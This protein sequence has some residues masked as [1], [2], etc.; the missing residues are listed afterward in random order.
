MR[1]SPWLKHLLKEP[2]GWSGG[3]L[4]AKEGAGENPG[5]R[6]GS[7]A[8]RKQQGCGH[9]RR[10]G[11]HPVKTQTP[12]VSGLPEGF[13]G[14]GGNPTAVQG[15]GP[16]SPWAGSPIGKISSPRTPAKVPTAG[17]LPTDAGTRSNGAEGFREDWGR[18]T[19]KLEFPLGTRVSTPITL[20]PHLA[21]GHPV[22]GP[23]PSAPA[24]C[25]GYRL[26]IVSLARPAAGLGFTGLGR[27]SCSVRPRD[28]W[29]PG[30]PW[31][32][33]VHSV[34]RRRTR[35]WHARATPLMAAYPWLPEVRHPFGHLEAE[36]RVV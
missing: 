9:P 10:K 24:R 34:V 19:G 36:L 31:P 30:P 21:M 25:C 11:P 28:S 17:N 14:A 7:R 16:V 29:G 23:V 18:R 35:G 13:T 3:A 32:S 26:F 20:F 6:Q 22:P 12:P 27:L 5:W 2:G 33:W 4:R 1:R 8:Q 15:Q